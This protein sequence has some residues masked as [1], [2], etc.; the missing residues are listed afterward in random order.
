M[1]ETALKCDEKTANKY[2]L[3]IY[4]TIVNNDKLKN[5]DIESIKNAAITSA[6]LGIPVDANNYA[7]LIPYGNKVQLQMSY[8]G[9]VYIAKQDKDVDN[10]SAVLVYPDDTFSIDLGNNS[11]SHIPNLESSSYG[12]ESTIR[13]VYAIVRFRHA[14]GRTQMFEVMTKKQV[15]EIRKISQAGGQKDKWGKPTIW[16]K[17]YGEMARKT[18]IKRLCKHAQLGDVAVVDQIDNAIH[19][20]KIIN[21]TP[22]GELLVDDPD[23]KLKNQI[24][25]AVNA[26]VSPKELEDAQS[27]YQDD[28]QELSLYNVSASKEIMKEMGKAA[29]S[30]Y[31]DEVTAYLESCEDIE[32]VDKVYS[33]HEPRI[34]RLKATERNAVIQTYV[35][36]KQH[37]IDVA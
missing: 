1:F 31:I 8:K 19:E 2:L 9:Y 11:M 20:N 21:V 23:T 22:E 28:L 18:A 12:D 34:N 35:D 29:D 24:I 14:T 6:T 4:N 3:G 30:L 7:Y 37:F 33:T 17:H 26:C 32:S 15:D 10:I 16:E 27:K 13:F 5:C 36:L 25:K